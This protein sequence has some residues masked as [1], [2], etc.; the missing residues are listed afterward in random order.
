M[1]QTTRRTVASLA[2]TAIL[3]ASPVLGQSTDQA[4]AQDSAATADTVVATVAGRDITLGQLILVRANLPQ[5][6][7]QIPDQA[8]FD[9]I[10]KQ[11][12]DETLLHMEAEER[13]LENRKDLSLALAIQR[14]SVL[15]DAA[16]ASIIEEKL[17]EEAIISAYEARTANITPQEEIRASHILVKEKALADEIAGKISSGGDFA[18]LAAEHGTDGTKDRGG[19]L[20]WFIEGDMIPEFSVAAFALTPGQVSEPVET[21]FGWH[22][23]KLADRRPR[24]AP[25]LEEAR[26]ALVQ[27]LTRE[28]AISSIDLLR[29]SAEISYPETQPPADVIRNDSIVAPN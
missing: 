22:L 20:G 3:A 1:M 14:R 9:A 28:F 26:P 19:D 2:L 18:E 7:Q 15:A 17:T 29:E 4:T 11:I 27:E 25:T 10:L 21:Q 6:Y 24:A 16:L 23:I 8:L 13:E 12:V 5:Q